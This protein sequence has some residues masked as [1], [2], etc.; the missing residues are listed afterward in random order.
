LFRID[1]VFWGDEEKK[2]SCLLEDKQVCSSEPYAGASNDT[3]SLPLGFC[4]KSHL[5]KAGLH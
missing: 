5:Q 2:E 3:L 4:I 1:N